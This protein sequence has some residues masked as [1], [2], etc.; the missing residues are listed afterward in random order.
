MSDWYVVKTKANK[1]EL[2]KQNLINQGYKVYLPVVKKIK[3]V[4]NRLRFFKQALFPNYLFIKFDFNLINWSKINNTRGISSIVNMSNS[5]SS[6]AE[7]DINNLK[8]SEDDEN[9]I[10]ISKIQV[11]TFGRMYK[12]LEG[13]F[14]GQEAKFYGKKDKNNIFLNMTLLGREIRLNLPYNFVQPI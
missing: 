10:V 6:V 8:L 4:G 3:K 2:A 12:I 7:E 1:E 11:P 14:Q 9:F 5:K 13:P